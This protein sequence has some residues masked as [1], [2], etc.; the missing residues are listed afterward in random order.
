M[1]HLT[2]HVCATSF[3]MSRQQLRTIL[4]QYD[5]EVQIEETLP[6]ERPVATIKGTIDAMTSVRTMEDTLAFGPERGCY[7]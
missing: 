6:H 5:L 3:D 2:C 4:E 7:E 1:T